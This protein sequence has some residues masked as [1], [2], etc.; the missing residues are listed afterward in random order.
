[1]NDTVQ[2]RHEMQQ[3]H[4]PEETENKF[5]ENSTLLSEFCSYLAFLICE[6]IYYE[7]EF[8]WNKNTV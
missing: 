3:K 8:W 6:V 7:T 5:T 2:S 1:M 4:W